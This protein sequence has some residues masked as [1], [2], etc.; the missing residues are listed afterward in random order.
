[1]SQYLQALTL[2]FLGFVRAHFSSSIRFRRP[3]RDPLT[4]PRTRPLFV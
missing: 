1:M 2:L 3:K 4:W